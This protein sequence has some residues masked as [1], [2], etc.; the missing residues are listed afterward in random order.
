LSVSYG[1]IKEIFVYFF[2]ISGRFDSSVTP[3]PR[4][5]LYSNGNQDASP[6]FSPNSHY[7][8]FERKRVIDN[9]GKINLYYPGEIFCGQILG[10][11]NNILIDSVFPVTNMI[12]GDKSNPKWSPRI[13]I[14]KVSYNYSS[15][16]SADDRSIFNI[17]PFSPTNNLI[18]QNNGKS[19]NAAWNPL[20]D[21]I[22]FEYQSNSG[23]N[24][25]IVKAGYPANLGTTDLI[26]D[27]QFEFRYPVRKPNSNLIAYVKKLPYYFVGDI[28]IYNLET[29]N[30][31]KLLPDNWSGT[32]NTLPAW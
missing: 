24:Y 13:L 9:N 1:Y 10:T 29:G 18:Y 2:D 21:G 7:L 17:D 19:G 12:S 22:I 4:K 26:S 14:N 32:N 15:A 11:G 28:W 6:C 16:D 30:T 8:A 5:L 31:F 27:N 25:K 23:G 3:N 20:C